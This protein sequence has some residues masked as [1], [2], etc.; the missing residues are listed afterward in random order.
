[1]R[2]GLVWT[3]VGVIGL[4]IASCAPGGSGGGG[5]GGGASRGNMGDIVTDGDPVEGGISEVPNP[6]PAMAA[7]SGKSLARLRRGHEVYMLKCAE[8]HVYMLPKELDL[9]EWEDALPKMIK[10]AGLP[11][12]DEQAVLDF[13][14]GVKSL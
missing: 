5:I 6:S 14:I 10:H 1:M 9:D 11:A 12:A 4:W 7:K 2:N 8:C 13:V 3:G